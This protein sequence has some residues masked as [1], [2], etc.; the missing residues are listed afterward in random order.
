M[1]AK[2]SGALSDYLFYCLVERELLN[3]DG[4]CGLLELLLWRR[5]RDDILCILSSQRS[6]GKLFKQV[7][8]SAKPCYTLKRED[9]SFAGVHMLDLF[10]SSQKMLTSLGG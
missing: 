9:F 5:F 7:C 2:H 10:V 3:E 4:S 6:S 8:D 1:G